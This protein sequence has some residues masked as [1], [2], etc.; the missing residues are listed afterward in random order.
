MF[1][2]TQHPHLYYKNII[3]NIDEDNYSPTEN[4]E[5]NNVKPLKTRKRNRFPIENDSN[6][7]MFSQSYNNFEP[8]RKKRRFCG[9]FS[10]P[11]IPCNVNSP[12]HR[13][14]V[15]NFVDGS[16]NL[17]YHDKLLKSDRQNLWYT[18]LDI[19]SFKRNIQETVFIVRE[20]Q[21]KKQQQLPLL[22]PVTDETYCTRGLERYIKPK[23]QRNRR[24]LLIQNIVQIH[25]KQRQKRHQK[26]HVNYDDYDLYQ[27]QEQQQQQKKQANLLAAY[28]SKV[29]QQYRVQA[30]NRAI[31]DE[32]FV[33][34]Q[35]LK[36][37]DLAKHR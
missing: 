2:I 29:S 12:H 26:S 1:F 3:T 5:T 14:R 36:Q 20:I 23:E 4:I 10:Q 25:L 17:V 19:K 27:L 18:P 21:K 34:K 9:I 6:D 8:S 33:A 16:K 35:F 31:K 28:S 32:I 11:D 13:R 15:V 24:N 30:R 7:I 37:H 22:L